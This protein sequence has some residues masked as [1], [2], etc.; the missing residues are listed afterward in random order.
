MNGASAHTRDGQK[1]ANQA[2]H[3][4]TRGA[5]TRDAGAQDASPQDTERT[6]AG[7]NRTAKVSGF[8]ALGGVAFLGN[9]ATGIAWI[10][11]GVFITLAALSALIAIPTGHVARFRGRRLAGEGRGLALASILTGWLVLLV[12]ALAILAFV[13]LIAGLAI[14]SDGS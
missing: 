10:N 14:L 7:R 8:F 13:G 12:C 3:E 2:P 9:F 5:G 6:L 1:R 4:G 11:P